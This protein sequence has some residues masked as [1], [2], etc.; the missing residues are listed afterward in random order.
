MIHCRQIHLMKEIRLMDYEDDGKKRRPV[1]HT[2]KGNCL[3]QGCSSAPLHSALWCDRY[4]ICPSPTFFVAITS[5]VTSTLS[6]NLV[7]EPYLAQFWL[8]SL[9]FVIHSNSGGI[10]T[11]FIY[12]AN[13]FP[14]IYLFT[15]DPR[16]NR[17][18]NRV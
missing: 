18:F 6:M 11:D 15:T 2:R 16:T 3:L 8:C 5:F 4:T 10:H 17:T 9:M 12:V 14:S 7:E 1:D 13:N